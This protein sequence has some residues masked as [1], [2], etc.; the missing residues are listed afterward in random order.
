MDAQKKMNILY[1]S[2][3]TG[4][5]FAGPNHS[6]PAQ[7]KA[8]AKVDN[9]LLYNINT[10]KRAEWTVEGLDC[11]NINDFP[12]GRLADLPH[13][14]DT[15]DV[16][17]FEEFYCYPFAK[18]VFDVMKANIPYII[19]PRSE[20]TKQAQSK[21]ALKKVVGNLLFF[22]RFSKNARAIQYLTEQEYVDS[23]DKWNKNH[24]IIS[25]G[26]VLPNVDKKT[27][28][29]DTIR[30]LYIGRYEIYQKGLDL[31]MGAMSNTQ[32][33][34]RKSGFKLEMYGVDQK[35]T[36][37]SL[38]KMIS[39]SGISD[40]VEINGPLY[41]EDKT[42]KLLNA[43]VFIMT[44]R[45]EGM[46]MGMIEALAYRL[47]CLATVGTN[48][49]R[50]IEEYRAGWICDTTQNDIENA[51]RNLIASKNTYESIGNNS[52]IMAEHYTWDGLA[53]QSHNILLR[54]LKY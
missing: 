12:S 29:D 23:G 2:N 45:F 22:K 11:K 37:A 10:V 54:L 17:V 31:L 34:L 8:Q 51:L 1:V 35:G 19:I 46:P 6:V 50:Q 42:E 24:I 25:N 9:V 44:S 18:I 4:N 43:D 15:P 33:E 32:Q 27:Y 52:R 21:K 49:T 40:L 26:T 7:V 41:G 47:P 14:F 13:P 39:N 20:L 5:L 48:L 3:L 38:N 16:V 30:A 28:S 53:E 36:V